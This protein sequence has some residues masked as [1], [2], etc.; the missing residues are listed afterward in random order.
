MSDASRL[1]PL[2]YQK[3]FQPASFVRNHS[4]LHPLYHPVICHPSLRLLYHPVINHFDLQPCNP[5]IIQSLIIQTYMCTC[6]HTSNRQPPA[7]LRLHVHMFAYIQLVHQGLHVHVLAH[8]QPAAGFH[9][10]MLASNHLP[11]PRSSTTLCLPICMHPNGGP[12]T[13]C[14][15]AYTYPTG[16]SRIQYSTACMQPTGSFQQLHDFMLTCLHISISY[17]TGLH[18]ANWQPPATP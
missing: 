11:A 13:S 9:I 3:S 16:S 18:T 14:S 4:N 17:S 10:Q 7:A 2:I 15:R 8:V 1:V 12:R 6:L 5:C